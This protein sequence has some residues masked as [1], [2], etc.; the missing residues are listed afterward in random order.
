M[1][2]M[3]ICNT[4]I[5]KNKFFKKLTL[6]PV[7][8]CRRSQVAFCFHVS[9]F[10]HLPLYT[11]PSLSSKSAPCSLEASVGTSWSLPSP[12]LTERIP[13]WME[14]KLSGQN[15]EMEAAP[16]WFYWRLPA[17]ASQRLRLGENHRL[18]GRRGQLHTQAYQAH[19]HVLP[20]IFFP[21]QTTPLNSTT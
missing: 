17:S 10:S 20:L 11:P 13:P 3:G 12:P 18:R 7:N 6:H 14:G 2:G 21:R 19:F 1:G 9:I 8:T 16:P 15:T 5:N 4:F